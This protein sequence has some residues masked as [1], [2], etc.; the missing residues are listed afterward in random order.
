MIDISDGLAADLGQ[1]L[2]ASL[3]GAELDAASVPIH[4]DASE[5]DDPLAAALYDGED[6]EL[7][8]ALPPDVATRLLEAQ[9]LG[10]KVTRIGTVVK[11]SGIVLLREGKKERIEIRGWEH[12]T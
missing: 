3:V 1:V 8:F 10:V 2:Q 9:P 11:G 6:Y 12:Q 4:P 7:L 5:R